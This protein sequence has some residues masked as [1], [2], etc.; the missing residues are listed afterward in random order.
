ME[1][2]GGGKT[3]Q[4]FFCPRETGRTSE[5]LCCRMRLSFPPLA[6]VKF[7]SLFLRQHCLKA[8]IGSKQG[9]HVALL[10]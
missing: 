6:A 9:A 5:D 8:S 10:S 3:L 2:E 1:R 7:T 4:T